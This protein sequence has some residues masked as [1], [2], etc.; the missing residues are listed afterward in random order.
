MTLGSGEAGSSIDALKVFSCTD[1]STVR[2]D[3]ASPDGARILESA[4]GQSQASE[5]ALAV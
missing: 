5:V 2:R 1:S 3:A 4:G